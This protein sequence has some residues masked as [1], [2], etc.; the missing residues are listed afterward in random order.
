MPTA[1]SVKDTILSEAKAGNY[2]DILGIVSVIDNRSKQLGV[3]YKDVVSAKG[4]F[5]AYGK[6]M[7]SGVSKYGGLVDKAIAEVAAKGP[8]HDATFYATPAAVKGLP[9]G[10]SFV[11]KT[12]GHQY[13]SDP[14]G[15]SIATAQG[16]KTPDKTAMSPVQ[17]TAPSQFAALPDV[18]PMPTSS[19]AGLLSSVAYSPEA[20]SP[21]TALAQDAFS[22]VMGGRISP[23]TP[24]Y[25]EAGAAQQAATSPFDAVL[26]EP[27][28]PTSR[29]VAGFK[30][31]AAADAFGLMAPSMQASYRGIERG[32]LDPSSYTVTS[33]AEAR[34]RGTPSKSHVADKAAVDMRTTGLDQKALDD[35]AVAA[36]YDKGIKSISWDHT[37]FAP[38]AHFGTTTP[39]GKGLQAKSDISKLSPDVQ[40]AMRGWD[41]QQRG[42]ID[43]FAPMV[44]EAIAPRSIASRAAPVG[45]VERGVLSDVPG[46]GKA[47]YAAPV[48]PVERGTLGPV[49]A[50]SAPGLTDPSVA[51]PVGQAYN[52]DQAGLTAPGFTGPAARSVSVQSFGPEGFSAPA[53]PSATSYGPAGQTPAGFAELGAIGKTGRA[54]VAAQSYAPAQSILGDIAMPTA[55][56]SFARSEMAK[57]AEQY[58]QYRSPPA[59]SMIDLEARGLRAPVAPPMAPPMA[60]PAPVRTAPSVAA[61]VSVPSAPAM[62]TAADVW[63]GKAPTGRATNG[64]VVSRNPDGTV[65]MTSSKY[66]YT[67]VDGQYRG[68]VDPNTVGRV[69]QAGI[70]GPLGGLLGRAPSQAA[71]SAPGQGRSAIGQGLRGAAGSV[72]GSMV[73]G[74]LGPVGGILGGYLGAQMARGKNPFSGLLG[75][76]QTTTPQQAMAAYARG[77]SPG[78]GFPEAPAGPA[79]QGGLTAFGEAASRGSFGG[80]AQSAANNPGTGLF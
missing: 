49:S 20:T 67:E 14:K 68:M 55:Q 48:G 79:S 58:G 31:Q 50:P 74:L 61:P 70:A 71:Q 2:Q 27:A 41:A 25:S 21:A 16:Y 80:Q 40:Q 75:R 65:S 17:D 32:L 51:A 28:A 30:S 39:Y 44:P 13:Y 54:G 35:L 63:G 57:M 45:A 15:R 11:A 3:S 73:G 52:I 69:G 8:V 64:N 24:S 60:R 77:Y 19:T 53:A 47:A 12:A 62:A 33:T 78:L 43:D 72:A 29:G 1:L 4:Q 46:Y 9:K 18:G 5:S 26:S 59:Y 34:G 42:L 10:L 38:H 37:A 22:A 7:P 6:A 36:M 76:S 23:P 56:P 66:G